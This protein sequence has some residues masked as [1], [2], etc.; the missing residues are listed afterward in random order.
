MLGYWQSV[1]LPEDRR[2]VVEL[3]FLVRVI[4]KQPSSVCVEAG[5]WSDE[6]V[7]T[8]IAIIVIYPYSDESVH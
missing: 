4:V 1:E 6:E 2:K 5:G 3:K 8:S 7:Y